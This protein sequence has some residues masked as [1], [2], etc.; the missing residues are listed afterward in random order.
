MPTEGGEGGSELKYQNL[1][2]LLTID[3]CCFELYRENF[4]DRSIIIDF[5]GQ[6]VYIFMIM[7]S[8]LKHI[9]N[10]VHLNHSSWFLKK[11]YNVSGASAKYQDKRI[12]VCDCVYMK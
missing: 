8:A 7:R 10:F 4:N 9:P 1:H 11:I 2:N 3:T 12:H 5:I 6:L